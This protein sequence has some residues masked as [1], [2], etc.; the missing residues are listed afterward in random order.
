MYTFELTDRGKIALV[1]FVA[2]II[3][4]VSIIL[5]L[6]GLSN[7]SSAAS[8]PDS[9]EQA[10][11]PAQAIDVEQPSE[12]DGFPPLLYPLNDNNAEDY[13]P[14][15]DYEKY[16]YAKYDDTSSEDA[17]NDNNE[18]VERPPEIGS[19]SVNI[20]AGRFTFYW[21]KNL[22]TSLD[23]ETTSMLGTFLAS[24]KN[25]PDSMIAIE[26]PNLSEEDKNLF[27][28]VMTSALGELGIDSGRITHIVDPN[29]PLSEHIEVNLYYIAS[30]NSK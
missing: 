16:D 23:R 1:L 28:S 17:S 26:T 6:V 18:I 27:I 25:T 30:Q 21:S 20:T 3:L 5:A 29:I 9:N 14:A 10:V 7:R 24:P 19:P 11:S 4:V 15:T 12:T 22:Q 2:S 13:D 8:P